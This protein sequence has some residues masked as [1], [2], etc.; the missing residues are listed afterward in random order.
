MW[1]KRL[2][3]WVD[4]GIAYISV[5]FTWQLPEAYS[6]C[7]WYREQGY[8]VLVGGPAVCLMPDY[9]EGV[10]EMG[11][12]QNVLWR[13][14]PYATFTSRGCIRSCWFCAVPKTEGDL[15]EL[16]DFE[17]KPIVCDNN[18]LACSVAHF[19]YVVDCLKGLVDVDFNQGL[20]ARLLTQHHIDRL[21]E[22][23]LI[24]LRFAWDD[25]GEEKYVMRAIR[26]VLAGGFPKSRLRCY[27]LFNCEDTPDDA[28]YRCTTLKD[29]GIL[30]NVQRYQPL[31]TLVKNSHIGEHW[32]DCHLA[33]FTRYWSRQIYL[34]PIPFEDYCCG[35]ERVMISEAQTTMELV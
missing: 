11:G 3:D 23:E 18:I 25:I 4:R 20:D 9:L 31:E 16:V 33:D 12:G 7:V 24:Y 29:M 1:S 19:D 14:N 5:V 21:K 32:T 35:R 17:V 13:H 26:N 10:A 22:L 15:V 2:I 27:V 28:L 6:L 8:K 34:S 30:P